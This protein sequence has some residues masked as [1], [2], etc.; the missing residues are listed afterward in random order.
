VNGARKAPHRAEPNSKPKGHIMSNKPPF[1]A[2]GE[3][4]IGFKRTTLIRIGV[5][6]PHEKGNGMTVQV[7][8]LPLNFD[9]RIVLL[10][11]DRDDQR[12]Q[13]ADSDAGDREVI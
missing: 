10:E 7:E 4:Q 1:N 11:A 6:W 5:A 2:Y 12:S 3:K 9:G 8:S 13:D